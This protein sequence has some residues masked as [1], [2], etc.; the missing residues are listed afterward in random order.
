MFSRS[1]SK[2][3]LALFTS[4]ILPAVI[5]AGP[6]YALY[7]G[8]SVANSGGFVVALAYR[9]SVFRGNAADREFCTGALID[10]Q[11]VLTAAHCL[12]DGTRTRDYEVVLGRT[13]LS[14]ASGEV[15][16]PAQQ[17]INPHYRLS[18]L[19]G[20]DV[21]L[22]RLSRPARETPARIAKPRLASRW[23]PGHKLMVYG[24][25][26]TCLAERKYCQGNDLKAVPS[27]VRSDRHCVR[28]V[29]FLHRPTEMCTKTRRVT[30]ESGDS[31]GPA[32]ILTSGG[33]RLVAV[34]S[35]GQLNHKL[36][37][38]VGGWM[39]YA[40][41]AGTPLADWITRITAGAA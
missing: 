6:A 10:A 14:R 34:S 19:A 8:N 21:A 18:G 15:I 9:T 31:G 29:G 17:F 35:W 7:G 30:L 33:A 11:W 40:E 4:A 12:A 36:N 13:R 16:R 28:A 37:L 3:G 5:S 38:V 32:V 27:K 1:I 25:G 2:I 22:I 20:H 41:V 26:Y 23:A 39:G 24:W